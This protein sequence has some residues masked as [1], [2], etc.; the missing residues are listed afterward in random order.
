[1]NI[2]CF[3]YYKGTLQ[4]NVSSTTKKIQELKGNSK[5]L[6]LKNVSLFV[7]IITHTCFLNVFFVYVL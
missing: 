5:L 3:F 1:M 4:Q 6:P 2:D 7:Q